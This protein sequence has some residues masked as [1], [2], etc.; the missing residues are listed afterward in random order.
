[1]IHIGGTLAALAVLAAIPVSAQILLL[2]PGPGSGIVSSNGGG[3]F[4]NGL[5]LELNFNFS[6]A[7]S[8][9]SL[10]IANKG[11]LTSTASTYKVTQFGFNAPSAW[12]TVSLVPPYAM[13]GSHAITT[14]TSENNLFAGNSFTTWVGTQNSGQA[15]QLDIDKLESQTLIFNF[16]TA[17]GTGFNLA[18]LFAS[19][20]LP[21]LGFRIQ[22]MSLVGSGVGSDKWVYNYSTTQP[23]DIPPP[24]GVPEPAT[25]GMAGILG[26]A[27]LI[28][29]RRLRAKK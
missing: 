9:L 18:G 4:D 19:I 17:P 27:T 26:L 16:S 5:T 29:F 7:P 28:G 2:N 15:D 6:Y 12:G 21:D 10:T 13:N 8:Q 24:S 20:I 25:Y 23:P 14:L 1:M 11:N 3:S 22:P